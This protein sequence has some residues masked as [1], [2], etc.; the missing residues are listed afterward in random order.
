MGGLLGPTK[1]VPYNFGFH[2]VNFP[3]EAPSYLVSGLETGGLE[4][5]CDL[6]LLPGV[7]PQD[8]EDAQLDLDLDDA[9]LYVARSREVRVVIDED[10]ASDLEDQFVMAHATGR[11]PLKH[12][13]A[14]LDAWCSLSRLYAKS[15]GDAKLQPHHWN[16]CFSLEAERARRIAEAARSQRPN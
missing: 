2:A 4:V 16:Y 1:Q 3:L 12:A 8:L 11:I 9:R 6:P 14:R 15:L 7:A 13:E 5:D 10:A